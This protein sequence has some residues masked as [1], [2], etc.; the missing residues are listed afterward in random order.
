MLGVQAP[1]GRDK[2]VRAQA[3]ISGTPRKGCTGVNRQAAARAPA[4][5]VPARR[6][7]VL[8]VVARPALLGQVGQVVQ[9]GT[10]FLRFVGPCGGLSGR[11][12]PGGGRLARC[13]YRCQPHPAHRLCAHPMTIL[14]DTGHPGPSLRR[15]P[16]PQ[17]VTGR[18][19]AAAWACART[20]AA[21]SLLLAATAAPAQVF[22]DPALQALLTAERMSDLETTAN[23][24][25]AG[26]P[27]DAQAVLGLAMS[28]MAGNDGPRRETTIRRAEACIKLTPL[29]AE[30]HYALGTVLGVH[31]M[32]QGMVKMASSV[33]T[34]KAALQESLRLAPQWYPARSAVVEFY[35]QAPGLI[36]GSTAKA[37]EAARTAAKPEQARA[38]EARVALEDDRFDAALAGLYGVQ[39]GTDS[40]LADDVQQWTAQAG[41]GLL[42]KGEAAKAK[43]VFERLLREQPTQAVGAYGLARTLMEL[44]ATVEATRLFEQAAK[45][46]GATQLPVDYRLG[47]ALQAQGQTEP[48]RAAY[49]RF[50][51]AG[52]SQGKSLDD[53]RKR[54]AQLGGPP[55]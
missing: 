19:P 45:L 42:G 28:A 5:A 34:V 24:R 48:A 44:G 38:L 22:K 15:P 11:N 52:R 41:F 12:R 54:L 37:T 18:A 32:T 17:T 43:P 27:D 6:D 13:A 2:R 25:L 36:G 1:G 4:G 3:A 23:Q 30:C 47:L 29:A 53:A 35:L 51:A 26:H 49:A 16:W 21:A 31:A 20:L 14:F 7:A 33:G 46:K 40:A 9:F 55:A 8:P 10:G 39:A 50:V